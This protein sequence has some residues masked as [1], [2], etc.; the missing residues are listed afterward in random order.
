[1]YDPTKVKVDYGHVRKETP[2]ERI[3]RHHNQLPNPR[4]CKMLRKFSDLTG[5]CDAYERAR[6]AGQVEYY[7]LGRKS[8]RA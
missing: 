2:K 4:V 7:K 5:D 8:R 3:A 1:M 6:R